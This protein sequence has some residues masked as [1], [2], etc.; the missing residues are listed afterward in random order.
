MYKTVFKRIIDLVLALIGLLCF[1][2]IIVI[3]TILLLLVNNGR[4]FFFQRRPGK[5]EKIFSIIK[6][7]TMNDKTDENGNLLPD[8][9]RLTP[10]GKF[11]RKA[12]LDELL[13]LVNVLKGDMSLIGPRP[14][15]P[16]YLPYYTEEEKKRHLV[17]PGITGLAQVNG[18]NMIGWEKKLKL[19]VEYVN[20]LSFLNDLKILIKTIHKVIFPKEVSVDTTSV[21]PYL[22]EIRREKSSLSN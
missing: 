21:E 14:L 11:I 5:N 4:P 1:S 7:K 22:D 10:V 20:T 6:F 17:K 13:Q 9:F 19:D 8:T 12:S 15:L 18:R 3:I 16:R 2:P